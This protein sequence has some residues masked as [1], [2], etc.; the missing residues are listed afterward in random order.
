MKAGELGQWLPWWVSARHAEAL[1]RLQEV[2]EDSLHGTVRA[3][4][5]SMPS[6]DELRRPPMCTIPL[7]PTTGTV[8]ADSIALSPELSSG[9]GI[10]QVCGTLGAVFEGL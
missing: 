2:E 4:A 1:I 3:N 8:D 5:A 7:S 10:R 9:E 6:G